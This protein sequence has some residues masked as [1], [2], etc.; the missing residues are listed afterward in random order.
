MSSK[1]SSR[2]IQKQKKEQI[3]EQ[4]RAQKKEQK[5]NRKRMFPAD[6]QRRMSSITRKLHWYGIRKKLLRFLF[7]DLVFFVAMALLWCT[8]KEYS[9]LGELV[10]NYHRALVGSESGMIFYQVANPDGRLLLS[11]Q[12]LWPLRVMGITTV[13]LFGLQF[14]DLLTSYFREDREIRRI[15]APINEIALK[16]DE[17]SKLSF[18]EDKYQLIEEA[19][20]N[21]QPG[22]EAAQAPL[23]FGDSDLTGVEAAMNNL[24]L[25]MRDT[26]RQQARFVNDASHELRTPIAVIQGYA[27]MLDRWGKSDE[28]ILEESITAIKNESEHM[29]HLVEQLLFLARG[30][31]GKT[32]LKK[33]PLQVEPLMQEIYEE[34]FMIDEKHRYRLK[35]AGGTAGKADAGAA[36]KADITIQADVGLL[37]QAVRILIDNAAKYTPEGEEIILSCGRTPAG[38]PYLQV[39]DQGI[40][41]NESELPHIFERFFRSDEVRSSAGTGL[42]LSIAKWIVDKHQGHFEILTRQDLG[43]RIRIVFPAEHERQL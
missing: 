43:T 10:W 25:R 8:E 26:L 12:A 34:S 7:T 39:Q 14:F 20:E 28:K 27:N 16:A 37:K 18:S 23:S 2:E 6:Q 35:T 32:V 19:I 17:L 31:S 11:V 5:K 21:I 38:E 22:Q 40:G 1:K 15:L 24:L 3:R 33:E 36:G 41:M 29:N 9:K 13:S 42:G 4:K 30:D